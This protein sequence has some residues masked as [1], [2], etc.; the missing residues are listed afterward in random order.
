MAGA[1]PEAELLRWA[2]HAGFEHGQV[3]ER[4][5][6]FG[7]TDAGARVSSRLRLHGMN[8]RAFA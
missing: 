7:G 8:F 4:F 5:N 1:L 6:A 2:H 3:V